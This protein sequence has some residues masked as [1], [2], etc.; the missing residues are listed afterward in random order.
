MLPVLWIEILCFL[1]QDPEFW[2]NL[3]I[4]IRIRILGLCYQFME[5]MLKIDKEKKSSLKNFFFKTIGKLPYVT[6]RDF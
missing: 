6:G 1:D 3:A 2:P 4:W 5:K